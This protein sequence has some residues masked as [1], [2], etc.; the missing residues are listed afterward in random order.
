MH[1]HKRSYKVQGDRSV[2]LQDRFQGRVCF[3]ST[4]KR[5]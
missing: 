2:Q 4:N 5:A 3:L 1:G